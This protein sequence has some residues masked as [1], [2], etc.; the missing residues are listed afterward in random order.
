MLGVLANSG[1]VLV[2]GVIGLLFREKI[3]EKYTT[4]LMAA[5]VSYTHLFIQSFQ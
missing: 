5:P 2:G 4:A 3:K 1:A